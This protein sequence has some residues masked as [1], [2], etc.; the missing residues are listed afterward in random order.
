MYIRVN[1]VSV[2]IR[3]IFRIC[4]FFCLFLVVIFCCFFECVIVFWFWL[5]E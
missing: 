5:V 2:E 1:K 4:L 3:K